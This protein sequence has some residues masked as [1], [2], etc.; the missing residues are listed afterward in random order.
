MREKL[1]NSLGVFGYILWLLLGLVLY[2]IPLTFLP[3]SF[4]ESSL[5]IFVISAIPFVGTLLQ[6][7]VWIWSFPYALAG[8]ID[9]WVI[10][11]FVS[12]LISF[13][14]M[15]LPFITSLFSKR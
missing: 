7:G 4:L 9:I 14:T 11:Y 13:L 2:I 10:L 12:L 8:P 3:L 1:L 5:I 15:I 6:I